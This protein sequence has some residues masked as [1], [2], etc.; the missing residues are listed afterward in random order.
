MTIERESGKLTC[1]FLVEFFDILDEPFHLRY[2]SSMRALDIYRVPAAR[3][4]PDIKAEI[5]IRFVENL[6]NHVSRIRSLPSTPRE[7]I[8]IF[9]KNIDDGFPK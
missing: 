4:L 2:E 6:V 1:L 5:R 3:A 9:L 8:G 7:N